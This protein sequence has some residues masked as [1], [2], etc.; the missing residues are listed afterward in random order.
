MCNGG[1][2]V[3]FDL[4]NPYNHIHEYPLLLARV[5]LCIL[6]TSHVALNAHDNII[7]LTSLFN[8]LN[9]FS[10]VS[11]ICLPMPVRLLTPEDRICKCI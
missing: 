5:L 11:F 7:Y 8:A 1:V 4:H 6:V 10:H 3:L 2:T 9:I